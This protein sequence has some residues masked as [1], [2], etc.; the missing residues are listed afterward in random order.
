MAGGAST[1]IWGYW[2]V[3]TKSIRVPLFAGFLVF[4]GG[5]VGIATIQPGDSARACIFAGMAGIG[6][7]APLVLVI[8]GIQLVTPHALIATGTSLA[9]AS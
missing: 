6:F 1:V 9:I 7:G 5:I 8:A 3:K 4:T 2:S